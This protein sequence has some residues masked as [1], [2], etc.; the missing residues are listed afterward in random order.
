MNSVFSIVESYSFKVIEIGET[1]CSITSSSIPSP[2]FLATNILSWNKNLTCRITNTMGLSLSHDVLY[3]QKFRP[4]FTRTVIIKEIT[5]FWRNHS[6]VE[7]LCPTWNHFSSRNQNDPSHTH[8]LISE[9]NFYPV[10][11]H[12]CS[13]T[14]LTCSLASLNSSSGLKNGGSHHFLQRS[15]AILKEQNK[16]N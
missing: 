5:A 7:L 3:I 15:S 16:P 11:N 9:E 6:T 14:I 1:L 10:Q 12:N 4:S 8:A 2:K 13:F